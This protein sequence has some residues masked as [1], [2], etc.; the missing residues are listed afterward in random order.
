MTSERVRFFLY[1]Y[2]ALMDSPLDTLSMGFMYVA[3]C[4]I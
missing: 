1:N 3:A 2:S 4:V